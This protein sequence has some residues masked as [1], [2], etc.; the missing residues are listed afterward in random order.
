MLLVHD[1]A[2]AYVGD[3]IGSKLN[4]MEK[5]DYYKKENHAMQYIRFR[6]SVPGLYGG[7]HTY[8]RW[9]DFNTATKEGCNST[10]NAR[11][12]KDL[13]RLDNLIQLWIYRNTLN[14]INTYN[15][16]ES[17]L[18]QSIETKVISKLVESFKQTCS[19]FGEGLGKKVSDF[20][21]RGS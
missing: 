16:F 2:E 6:S 12:A 13:D 8:A 5:G 4:C 10:V 17:S 9:M 7:E 19:K 20:E 14:D 1:I 3:I 15:E 18:T 11:I 21:F